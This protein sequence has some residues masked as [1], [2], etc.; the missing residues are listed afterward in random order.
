LL[1]CF[2]AVAV[3]F[4]VS[5]AIA[6][7]GGYR[8]QHA[9]QII[10]TNSSP[11]QRHLE[12]MRTVLRHLLASSYRCAATAP[13]TQCHIPAEEAFTDL[14][15]QWASYRG[16]PT[17]PGERDGWNAV[18][19][20]MQAL[21]EAVPDSLPQSEIAKRLPEIEARIDALDMNLGRLIQLNLTN[22]DLLSSQIQIDGSRIGLLALVMD[23]FGLLFAFAMGAVALRVVQRYTR[24]REETL[25]V[26]S[27]RDDLT[28]LYNR[29][30]LFRR[31]AEQIDN[32][33]RLKQR[34]L[35]VF[36]DL[37]ELKLINDRLGHAAGDRALVETAALLRQTF[38]SSDVL[39][40]L[41]GDEFV[42][43]SPAASDDLAQ[44]MTERLAENLSRRNARAEQDFHLGISI[45]V[46]WYEP[47]S[48]ETLERLL[49]RADSAM[50]REK[51]LR[52][53]PNAS[54]I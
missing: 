15:A 28:G 3:C 40:R 18:E 31:A 6:E 12:S 35:L 11:S 21:R 32:A 7:Y 38:R 46:A 8:I 19:A 37:D 44:S 29:R 41:G 4:A 53:E 43:L 9:A 22:E 17:F 14:D 1:V 23:G 48:S 30:G 52:R 16:L 33:R 20:G 5:T 54:D 34:L 42:A 49:K 39:A 25:S 24:R 2:A 45:G 47:E 51:R 13:D 36:A 10:A 27:L 26:L 50:Y